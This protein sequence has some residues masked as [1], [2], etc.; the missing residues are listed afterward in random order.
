MP[1]GGSYATPLRS[2]AEVVSETGKMRRN[3]LYSSAHFLIDA[4]FLNIHV[5]G[6][7]AHQ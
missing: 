7:R 5:A 1:V 2:F 3:F 4:L 6:F